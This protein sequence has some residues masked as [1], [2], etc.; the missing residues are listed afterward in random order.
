MAYSDSAAQI[1]P[2]HRFWRLYRCNLNFEAVR[3]RPNYLGG[4]NR[5]QIRTQQVKKAPLAVFAV[6]ARDSHHTTI[7]YFSF[8]FFTK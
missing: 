4:Q 2:R 3:P 6:F 1:T 5:C 8:F 7:F